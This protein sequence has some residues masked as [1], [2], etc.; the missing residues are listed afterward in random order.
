MWDNGVDVTFQKQGFLFISSFFETQVSSHNQYGLVTFVS[1]HLSAL[2]LSWTIL[3]QEESGNLL[4][5]GHL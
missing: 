4:F 1:L 2:I 5:L 3:R